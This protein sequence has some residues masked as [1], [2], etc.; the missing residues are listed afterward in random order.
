MGWL[1]GVLVQVVFDWVAMAAM[2]C[3]DGVL[4]D[5]KSVV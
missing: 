2:K 1:I 5:R 3:M 4:T